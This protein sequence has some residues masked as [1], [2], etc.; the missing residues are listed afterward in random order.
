MW[1]VMISRELSLGRL[2]GIYLAFMVLFGTAC[3]VL[4]KIGVNARRAIMGNIIYAV[5]MAICILAFFV[6]WDVAVP[7]FK[8]W[9]KT[10]SKF[11][12][13]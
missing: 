12:G 2:V 7:N 4:T 3:F 5:V 11:G 8:A 6:D 9:R 1:S 13:L 10:R